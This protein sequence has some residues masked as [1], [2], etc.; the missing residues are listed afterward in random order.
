MAL[1]CVVKCIIDMAVLLTESSCRNAG[2]AGAETVVGCNAAGVRSDCL[3]SRC[4]KLPSFLVITQSSR[5][6][7]DP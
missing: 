1:F 2:G 5:A 7:F 6:P 3:D 4:I